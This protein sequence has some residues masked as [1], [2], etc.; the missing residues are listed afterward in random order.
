[1]TCE[2]KG[3]DYFTYLVPINAAE[4]IKPVMVDGE[5]IN[6]KDV[7][8]SPDGQRLAFV[9]DSGN[10]A[11]PGVYDI[12]LFEVATGA[13]KWL[14]AAGGELTPGD[15][16]HPAWSPDGRRLAYV[17]SDGPQTWLALQELERPAP[18]LYQ[19]EPG[20]HYKP[21]FT[22]DGGHL[23]FIF[24]NPRHPDDLWRLR[25]EDGAFEQLTHSLVP[26]AG[27]GG[28]YPAAAHP[29]P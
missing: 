10:H 27:A 8:W 21:V 2:G 7:S 20:I 5:L 17:L 16:G 25:L 9:S 1:M 26:R 28:F 29:I 19:V 6:A 23:F 15:K 3:Q 24:D 12:G 4:T 13:I 18:R 22:P 11:A 14:N